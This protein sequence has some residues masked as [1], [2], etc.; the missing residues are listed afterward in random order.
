MIPTHPPGADRQ[1]SGGTL[2][3]RR[4]RR[5]LPLP[6]HDGDL[7]GAAASAALARGQAEAAGALGLLDLPS[8]A[9]PAAALRPLP[10][11][12]ALAFRPHPGTFRA[13]EQGA[14]SGRR[15]GPWPL[16]AAA[17]VAGAVLVSAPLMHQKG[18][19]EITGEGP[20]RAVPVA[21]LGSD[22]H[23]S[24][25]V[26][27][28]GTG[29]RTGLTDGTVP[30][31]TIPTTE[32]PRAD[33]H[34]RPTV[35]A[36]GPTSPTTATPTTSPSTTTAAPH[37]T[38]LGVLPQAAPLDRELAPHNFDALLP[39]AA[40]KAAETPA[41]PAVTVTK[42]AVQPAAESAAKPTTAK[43]AA[44]SVHVAR[45]DTAKPRTVSPEAAKPAGATSAHTTDAQPPAPPT[46]PAAPQYGTRVVEGTTVL[47]A[48]QSVSTDHVRVAMTQGG[49]LEIG[50][51]AD[52]SVLW[53]SGTSGSG[54]Y[55]VF[56]AD[57][58]LVVYGADG[59][60]LWT[61]GSAGNE[62][63]HMVL[64]DDGNVVIRSAGGSPVWSS[65]TVH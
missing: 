30:A 58:N 3:A 4:V 10:E 61:S 33:R 34:V 42:E 63:A 19:K 23:T 27:D 6:L 16:V 62:G 37:G 39:G 5:A 40:K 1:D 28:G 41:K 12:A 22:G 50:D 49:N 48:G 26:S 11:S 8:A 54:N 43:P 44:T 15:T 25:A 64:Q 24:H 20:D 32:V 47:H 29:S 46:K 51:P 60:S 35:R 31:G 38:E 21:T 53:S 9:E 45:T 65:H 14:R 17:A 36:H 57:G 55:A 13:D 56:Q 52:G 59:N 7:D 18:D 2:R